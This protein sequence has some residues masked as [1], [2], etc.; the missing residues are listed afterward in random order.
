MHS[1]L[2]RSSFQKHQKKRY[3]NRLINVLKQKVSINKSKSGPII[4]SILDQFKKKRLTILIPKAK[5]SIFVIIEINIPMI[6]SDAYYAALKLK[7]VLFLQYLWKIW[8]HK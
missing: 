2:L 8:N 1:H 3:K 6:N 7:V 4:I 5:L